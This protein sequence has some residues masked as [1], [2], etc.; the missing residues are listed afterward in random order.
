MSGDRGRRTARVATAVA[1][2]FGLV[3][4]A[5]TVARS[6]PEDASGLP[7]DTW[8]MITSFSDYG[9]LSYAVAGVAAV[10]GIAAR[11]R[12]ATL[13]V[14]GLVLALAAV[15]ASWLLPR[16]AGRGLDASGALAGR[17]A[18]AGDPGFRLLSLNMELGHADPAAVTDAAA[19]ADVVV[20]TEATKPT[21]STLA[22]GAFGARF[23]HRTPNTLPWS[24]AA[25]TAVFSRYPLTDVRALPGLVHQTWAVTV[26]LPDADP[27]TVVGVHPARPY[28]GGHDWLGEQQRLRELVP[29]GERVVV[30]GDFN[31]VDSHRPI[32]ALRAAGYRS[33]TELAAAGWQ[34]TY[35]A[36]RAFPPLLE[37]D[38]VLLAP[39]LTAT[40]SR[41]VPVRGTDHRGVLA[42]LTTAARA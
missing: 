28:L 17:P 21:V 29:P 34:P 26:R 30:A 14:G 27:V 20:L 11:R 42:T 33:S 36:D 40:A 13:A 31:A 35:P 24:G 1:V 18:A 2:P 15:H 7:S 8:V 10:V 39:G 37:I 22:A 3:G 19:A 32:R 4:A 5:T 12:P 6:L 16:F 41:A 23:P 9:L 25:G 38:H